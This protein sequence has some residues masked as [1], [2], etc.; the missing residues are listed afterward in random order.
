MKSAARFAM[1]VAVVGV[2]SSVAI[3]RAGASCAVQPSLQQSIE[4][5]PVVFVGT[6]VATSNGGRTAQVRVGSVWAGPKL[7]K[8][9]EVQGSPAADTGT[10]TSVDRRFSKGTKYLFV[11]IGN[12][13]R[14]PFSD[15][16]CSATTA[17]TR[18]I[19]RL[20]P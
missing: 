7:P 18:E 16:A 14:A 1:L 2:L 15:N 3:P 11:P 4:H 5:A 12:R 6:V 9:V 8:Q 19:A 13:P 17:F 10:A 20:A